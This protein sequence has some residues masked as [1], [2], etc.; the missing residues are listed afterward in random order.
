MV[1]LSHYTRGRDSWIPPECVEGS[2]LILMGVGG[3]PSLAARQPAD[4]GYHHIPA[5]QR[6]VGH[7][8]RGGLL[9]RQQLRA[10][11]RLRLPRSRRERPLDGGLEELCFAAEAPHR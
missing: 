10:L 11:L 8:E 2:P 5:E 9:R 1:P 6:E 4:A 3:S 7:R